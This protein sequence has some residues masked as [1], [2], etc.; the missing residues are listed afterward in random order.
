MSDLSKTTSLETPHLVLNVQQSFSGRRWLWRMP[1]SCDSATLDRQAQHIAQKASLYD[2]VGR[3][4]AVRG[5]SP[6]SVEHFLDPKLKNLLPNPSSLKDMDKAADRI[7]K[8]IINHEK[9]AIFGDYDVDGGCSS[10]I[11]KQFFNSLDNQPITYIPDRFKE[12][13]GPNTKALQ[14]LIDQGVTLI[15]CVDCGA[16][17]HAVFDETNQKNT[18]IIVL[19][20]HKCESAPNIFATVNPNRLDCASGLGY[21]C[22]GGVSF[23]TA[24]AITRALQQQKYF[25]NHPKPDLLQL[26]DLVAL[27]TICD[28]M[29]LTGL[30]R[31]L[32]T[33]GLKI[34]AKRERIGLAALLEVSGVQKTPDA[35]SCGFALGPR[36][37]AG[38]R[39]S[40]SDLGLKLLSCSN[41]IEAHQLA[42]RLDTINKQRQNVEQGMLQQAT[43]LAIEQ[44]EKG[45]PVILLHH[46]DWHP[47]IV[48]IVAGRI[49]EQLNRP[50]L[51]GAELSD[52]T[53]KGSGRSITGLDLGAAIIAARQA[54]LLLS[55]GGHAM[56][57]G[58]S[59]QKDKAEELHQFLNQYLAEASEHPTVVDL[60]IEGVSTVSGASV[61][62]AKQ[63]E[64]LTPFGNGNDE[65]LIALSHVHIIRSDRIGKDNNTLRLTLQGENGSS[66][67]ALMFKADQNP[68]TP[69]LED[70]NNRR[71]MHLAGWLRTNSWNGRENADFFIK[72]AAFA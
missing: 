67:K 61:E 23:I 57:A 21:L 16:A 43:D 13:Y 14:S 51:I 8:A 39:I 60:E 12:G 25:E 20:H 15:I 71:P 37:N 62:L 28:V 48:G 2:L 55:G 42:E 5:V 30:N 52:G 3:M 72:D 33:Q 46:A 6:Q 35:F 29:P 4:I 58:Y 64:R 47:G 45:A 31:A 69:Y 54:G 65:P 24:I 17:S 66:I 49:K 70:Y 9:I 68:I 26:L 7:A 19:D 63:I 18:D 59:Y 27:S 44:H 22:A 50:T 53:V 34:L 1:S 41:P 32:V 56:A 38:G 40:E 11:L 36:I 10:A